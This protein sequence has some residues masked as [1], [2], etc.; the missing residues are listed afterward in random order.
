MVN[1]TSISIQKSQKSDQNE[2]ING[3]FD[4]IMKNNSNVELIYDMDFRYFTDCHKHDLSS[5]QK[6]IQ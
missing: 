5:F 3:F 2:L 4:E 6:M 1:I